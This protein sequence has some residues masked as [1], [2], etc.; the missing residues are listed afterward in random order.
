MQILS[1]KYT[2]FYKFVFLFIW[3]V[4]FGLGAREV[5]FF[6][7][8]YD[9]RWSQYVVTW[10]AI[11]IF[12]FFA[13]GSIKTITMDRKKKVL[14]VSNFFKTHTISFDNIEDI[15]GSSLLSPKLVWFTLKTPSEFGRKI[16]FLPAVRPQRSIGKHPIV[17]DLRKEFTMDK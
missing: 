10:V 14:V 9:L 13:T 1:S 4:G 3:V 11:A 6:S 2:F 16:Y 5:I 12:I 17:I 8:E 15:D 7:P